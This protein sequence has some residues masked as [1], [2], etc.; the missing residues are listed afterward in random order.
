MDICIRWA[1]TGDYDSVESIM[2]QVQ[3]LHIDWR[4]DIYKTADPVYSR[5]LFADLVKQK[6]VLIAQT[7]AGVVGIA[8]FAYRHIASDKQVTR[9]VLFVEDLAVKDGYRGQGIGTLLMEHMKQ[10]VVSEHLDGLELQVNA[11]N[12]SAR[13]MY[14]KLGFTEKSINLELL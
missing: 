14:A 1:E 9:D 13:K 11:R 4:P 5:E 2:K 10:K 3:Q 12:T 7:D 8:T 6:H